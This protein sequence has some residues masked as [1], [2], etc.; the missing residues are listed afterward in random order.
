M[1]LSR[2][3]GLILGLALA[4][5]CLGEPTP[6]DITMDELLNSVLP[7]A[8]RQQMIENAGRTGWFFDGPDYCADLTEPDHLLR[9]ARAFPEP[10]PEQCL[11]KLALSVGNISDPDLQLDVGGLLYRHSR[12]EAVPV[13][14]EHVDGGNEDALVAL[15]MNQ[16]PAARQKLL[17]HIAALPTRREFSGVIRWAAKWEDTE[18]RDQLRS[19]FVRARQ[20][21]GAW[22][23]FIDALVTIDATDMVPALEREFKSLKPQSVT[24][25]E[26]AAAI[27][28]LSGG[29]KF[30]EFHQRELASPSSDVQMWP[31]HVLWSL[32]LAPESIGQPLLS[33]TIRDFLPTTRAQ[34]KAMG[35]REL[36]P[37]RLAETAAKVAGRRRFASLSED[38]EKLLAR[39]AEEGWEQSHAEYVAR[40]LLDIA[41]PSGR[42]IVGDKM[43]AEWL[44]RADA[45]RALRPMPLRFVPRLSRPY[46]SY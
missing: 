34:D 41:A 33:G 5:V 35:S 40:A 17:E 21:R 3:R 6:R 19:S 36:R 4:G 32:T 30:S 1:G 37:I 16:D 44:A 7:P 14:L 2:M 26:L 38:L 24:R 42:A 9:F 20:L 39:L 25:L 11:D 43:G 23:S 12:P 46:V 13:L 27:A 28:T 10:V 31:V 45:A 8:A 15:A 29:A 22:A 18:I